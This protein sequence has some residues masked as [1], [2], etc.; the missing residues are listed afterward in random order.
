MP[1]VY[2][3]TKADGTRHVTTQNN[4]KLKFLERQNVLLK[5]EEKLKWV[6]MD[7]AE[8]LQLIKTKGFIDPNHSNVPKVNILQKQVSEKDNE[9]AQLR[10]LLAEKENEVKAPV[11]IDVG[12]KEQLNGTQTIEL[13]NNA[14]SVTEIDFIIDGD[15]RT[16]VINAANKA[17]SKING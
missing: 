7:K 11:I 15:T 12:E 1:Q 16:T 8:A 3:V 17:K 4:A 14:K 9:I 2:L 6:S 13:I 10:A 5:P